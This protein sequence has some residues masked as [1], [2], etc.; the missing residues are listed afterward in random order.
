MTRKQMIQKVCRS[1]GFIDHHIR[2]IIEETLKLVA[3]MPDSEIQTMINRIRGRKK[4]ASKKKSMARICSKGNV[5]I[6]NP[7]Q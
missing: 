1:T 5:K 2:I 7:V 6:P 3:S 4:L